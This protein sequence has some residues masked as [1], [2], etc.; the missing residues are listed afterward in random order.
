M[1]QKLKYIFA[2]IIQL[3]V[4]VYACWSFLYDIA[5]LAIVFIDLP[6]L[7]ASAV[8]LVCL[9]IFLIKRKHK[10]LLTCTLITNAFI[11]SLFVLGLEMGGYSGFMGYYT[12][13]ICDTIPYNVIPPTLVANEGN[14]PTN[15]VVTH[16]TRYKRRN[17]FSKDF[18]KID[19]VGL[20]D[21]NDF[22]RINLQFSSN[23]SSRPL[24]KI[25]DF[26]DSCYI[27]WASGNEIMCD[28]VHGIVPNDTVLLLLSDKNGV[29]DTI[30]IIRLP[31]MFI[32]PHG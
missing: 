20:Y 21:W 9:L 29:N 30:R 27:C 26:P 19:S 7:I 32:R 2:L 24:P 8:I 16:I 6:L 12:K 28:F 18:V 22:I 11:I 5:P 13:R 14:C 23:D 31:W 17:I 15:V 3:T 25:S 4:L 10:K 1:L